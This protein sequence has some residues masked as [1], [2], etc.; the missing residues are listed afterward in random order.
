MLHEVANEDMED[1]DTEDDEDEGQA[2]DEEGAPDV[3][4]F[5]SDART[6]PFYAGIPCEIK[7]NHRCKY[8]TLDTL[9]FEEGGSK[10]NVDFILVSNAHQI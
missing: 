10:R 4:Q 3:V 9:A 1:E 2:P 5:S 8:F 6:A 7:A